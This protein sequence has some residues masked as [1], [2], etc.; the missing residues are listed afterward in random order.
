MDKLRKRDG[1]QCQPVSHAEGATFIRTWHYAHGCSNTSVLAMGLHRPSRELCGVTLWMPPAPGP[2]RWAA[3]NYGVE[4]NRTITLSRMA[5]MDDVPRNGASFLLAACRRELVARGWQFAV[6][7][8]D[9]EVGHDGHVYRAS[10]WTRAGSSYSA[11][12]WIDEEG[13]LRSRKSTGNLTAN[14]MRARGWRQKRGAPKPRY[15]L[16]L[17]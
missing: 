12:R 4:A 10:G 2:A 9:P 7:Y 5:I 17:R 14:E 1:W 8:A 6:T 15:I 13:R 11:P 16:D 3:K